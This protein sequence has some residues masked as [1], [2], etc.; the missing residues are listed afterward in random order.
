MPLEV[1]FEETD[2]AKFVLIDSVR[3]A[4]RPNSTKS[5]GWVPLLPGYS[6]TQRGSKIVIK[7]QLN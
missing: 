2:E 1:K 6:V 4:R 3:I 7:C 5:R